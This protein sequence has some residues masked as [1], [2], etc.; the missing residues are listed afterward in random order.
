MINI[1]F[2]PDFSFAYCKANEL[3][4]TSKHLSGFPFSA[5]DVVKETTGI[6]CRTYSKALKYGVD[7]SKFG[8]ESAVWSS[9]SGKNIIFYD[10]TK[11]D[12]HISYS[13]L[14]EFGHYILEHNPENYD[15]PEIYK[16]Y[17]IETNLFAAQILMP[18]QIIRELIKRG[19]RID[20]KF[21]VKNF[22]VSYTAAEKRI[23]AL[24]KTEYEG[25]SRSEKEY[26]DI[27]LSR[28]NLFIN[29]IAPQN[30]Y[31][32][33]EDEYRKQLERNLWY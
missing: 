17:E 18:E 6:V 28:F 29:S 4:I 11:P 9:M 16:L 20:Q 25:R 14:H 24:A 21:L 5:N 8:S 31:Y 27:I 10:E 7:V 2:E 26:D 1:Q 12:S 22:S 15:N 23:H 19:R 32:N 33:F 3:L 30:N 13:I